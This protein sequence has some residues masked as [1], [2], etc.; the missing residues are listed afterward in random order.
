MDIGKLGDSHHAKYFLKMI[1]N[2]GNPDVLVV[3]FALR[4]NLDQRCNAAAVDVGF[5]VDFQQDLVGPLGVGVLVGFAQKRLGEG[6]QIAP[7][8]K[9]G[10]GA[11]LLQT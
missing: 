3:A 7:D 9:Q 8:V 10:D 11:V 2:A 6:R 1:R 4:Q 5:P